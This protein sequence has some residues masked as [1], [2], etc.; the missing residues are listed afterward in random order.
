MHI[1]LDIMKKYFLF[2][3][4]LF[5]C[6]CTKAQSIPSEIEN[7]PL[8][9]KTINVIGD[10]YVRNHRCPIEESWHA[11]VAKKYHMKYNNYGRN[12][13]CI[14]FDRERFGKA[15]ITRYSEMTDSADYVL[16]IAG[17]NDAYMAKNNPD[18]LL[19]VRNA[20]EELCKALI[21][22]YPSAKIGFVTPW[23]VPRDGFKQVIDIMEDICAKYSIPIFNAAKNSG[24]Y[25]WDEEFRKLYFQSSMDTAHLNDKGHN[26][27]M[28]KGEKFLLS[29]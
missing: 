7:S 9:G 29:L 17:H 20:M 26:L 13:G 23:N 24:I 22:K 15:L 5:A 11:K 12:G 16:I 18:S 8:Y 27:F 10:S 25:V 28:N 4:L 2:V 14:A 21:T 19:M 1:K 6:L 3:F